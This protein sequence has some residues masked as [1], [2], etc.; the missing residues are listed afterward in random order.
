MSNIFINDWWKAMTFNR[1]NTD[2]NMFQSSR[3]QQESGEE[4]KLDTTIHSHSKHYNQKL[5]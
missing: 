2:N 3:G 4:L 5:Q 1:I